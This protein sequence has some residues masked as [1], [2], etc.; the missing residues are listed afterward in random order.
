MGQENAKASFMN[1]PSVAIIDK[2]QK[3]LQ[4]FRVK[5][6]LKKLNLFILTQDGVANIIKQFIVNEDAK[7]SN[8]EM[9][10][11]V[12]PREKV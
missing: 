12:N 1:R 8:A 4:R 3:K 5:N 11:K 10:P 7:K 9:L 2:N 6:E